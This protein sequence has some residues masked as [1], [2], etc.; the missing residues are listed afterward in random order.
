[1]LHMHFS[2]TLQ[3]CCIEFSLSRAVAQDIIKSCPSCQSLAQV[4][5]NDGVNPRGLKSNQLWQIDITHVNSFGHLK[6]VHVTVDTCLSAQAGETFQHV[7]N[8]YLEAF[9]VL[10]LPQH[11]KTDTGPTHASKA[12]AEF[13]QIWGIVHVTGIPYNPQGQAVEEHTHHK[14]KFQL[15]KQ[16]GEQEGSYCTRL[17]R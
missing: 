2:I 13:C 7:K 10:D 6:F 1:M 4:S 8:H 9:A 14:L 16:K 11:I 17:L 12:F 3:Q 15:K 5:T